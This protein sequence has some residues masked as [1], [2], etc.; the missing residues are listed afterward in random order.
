MKELKAPLLT[1]IS[2]TAKLVVAS[3]DVNV[4]ASVASLDVNPSDPSAAV[5]VMVGPVL[6]NVQLNW[7]AALLL[8]PTASAYVELATSIVTAPS[9]VGVMVAV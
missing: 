5:I 4:S 6:S 1:V 7:V 8:F 3:L 2:P 9:V